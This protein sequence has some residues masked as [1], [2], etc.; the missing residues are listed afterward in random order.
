MITVKYGTTLAA[1][2]LANNIVKINNLCVG[3]LLIIP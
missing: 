1:I 2:A 3:Q